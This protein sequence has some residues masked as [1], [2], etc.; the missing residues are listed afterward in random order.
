[1]IDSNANSIRLF[2]VTIVCMKCKI[3]H[4]NFYS[5]HYLYLILKKMEV[6]DRP[7]E[8]GVLISGRRTRS[9]GGTIKS[10]CW[11]TKPSFNP[12]SVQKSVQLTTWLRPR[13]LEVLLW[14]SNW[15]F[16]VSWM[17]CM[18]RF[19]VLLFEDFFWSFWVLWG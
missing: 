2:V 15:F 6:D 12:K 18:I 8:R 5:L 16:S 4:V 1:M 7:Q 19:I 3:Q 17:L 10:E 13:A 11:P 9:G 14:L